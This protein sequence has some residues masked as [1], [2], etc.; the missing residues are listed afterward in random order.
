ME[1]S[2]QL[3]ALR[4]LGADRAQGFLW[5]PALP[6]H[7]LAEWLR[8]HASRF[9]TSGPV[10]RRAA[11]RVEVAPGSDEERILQ[12]H[13][14]GAS[15]HTVAAALNAEGRR[16]PAGVRWHTRSVARVIAALRP[17]G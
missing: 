5:S 17:P 7:S 10:E 8:E 13:D 15:L 14:E 1:T 9:P 4:H 6:E 3:Q 11:P 12:L 2:G 16:T